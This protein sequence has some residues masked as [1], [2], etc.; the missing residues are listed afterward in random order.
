MTL[1]HIAV[2]RVALGAHGLIPAKKRRSVDAVGTTPHRQEMHCLLN[3]PGDEQTRLPAALEGRKTSV[4]DRMTP[5]RVQRFRPRT[6][7][8]EMQ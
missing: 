1:A 3:E 5:G 2:L 7:V 8:P 6:L 4:R